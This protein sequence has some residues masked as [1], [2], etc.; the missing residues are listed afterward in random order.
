MSILQAENI[1]F[2]YNGAWVLRDVSFAVQ[3]GDFVGLI[4]PNGTGKTT[5]LNLI[6][7]IL[8]S[9]EGMLRIHGVP[10]HQ[11]KRDVLAKIVAVVPQETPMIFPFLVQEVVLMGRAPHLGK[12]RFEGEK[13]LA[14]VNRAMAMTDTLSLAGRNM[15]R[16]S[17]GERQRVL[18]ARALAQEPQLMLL[19]EPTAS[20]DIRH[21][22]EF[23]NLIKTLNVT[24]G[25]TVIAATHDI[26]LASLYC[27]WIILLKEGRIQVA[28][29][30]AEVITEE[31]IQAVYETPVMVDRHPITDLPRVT[32]KRESPSETGSR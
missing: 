3:T 23:F 31:H 1:S 13:D 9:Q 2:S 21:Q 20:L 26:N 17:G 4:G 32:P 8:R 24:Q 15:N 11:M 16:L 5:L 18:I 27:D 28:G 10:V 12:W 22:V 29:R 30:P 14:I 6:D 7:G 25:L 19:D